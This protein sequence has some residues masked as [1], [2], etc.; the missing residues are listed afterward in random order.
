MDGHKWQEVEECY[1][2][3][4]DTYCV[5]VWSPTLKESQYLHKTAKTAV[6]LAPIFTKQPN[7][8]VWIS[9]QGYE[10]NKFNKMLS[11][12]EF[13]QRLELN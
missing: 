10:S 9:I 6:N 2:C 3:R 7:N 12:Q 8:E 5:F 4:R 11:L 13:C 1:L